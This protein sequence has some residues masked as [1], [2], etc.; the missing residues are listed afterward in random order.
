MYILTRLYSIKKRKKLFLFSYNFTEY[1]GLI[2]IS[3]S[4]FLCVIKWS[5]KYI[6]AIYFDSRPVKLREI[7]CQSSINL[8]IGDFTYSIANKIEMSLLWALTKFLVDKRNMWISYPLTQMPM[9]FPFIQIN[10]K[11][12]NKQNSK[13]TS[14]L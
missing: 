5:I 9:L 12:C 4:L 2:N 10:F 3:H 6:Y 8:F 11:V 1:E 13:W 7:Y 14:I